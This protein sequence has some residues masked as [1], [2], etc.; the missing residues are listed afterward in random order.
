MIERDRIRAGGA[1]IEYE[2]H[3]S[4]R[5]KKT[6]KITVED[7]IVRIFVPWNTQTRV[8]RKIVREKAQLIRDR[9]G[10]AAPLERKGK[11]TERDSITYEG[12]T[13]AYEVRRSRRRKKSI[14]MTLEKGIVKLAA[15]QGTSSDKLR[16]MVRDWA[17]Q[18]AD[19]LSLAP[20]EGVQKRFVSGEYMPYMGE[21][22][23][24]VIRSADVPLPV[25]AFDGTSG[26]E[27]YNWVLLDQP[28]HFSKGMRLFKRIEFGERLDDA[29]FRITVPPNM[30]KNE[31][32]NAVRDAFIEW[33]RER[34]AEKVAKCVDYHWPEVGRK[35]KPPI[36][37]RDQRRQWGSCASDGTLRFN[38]RLI[39][40]DPDLIEYIV[41]HELAHLR[42]R[43][44]SPR[45][46][47]RVADMVGDVESI[48]RRLRRVEGILPL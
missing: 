38:W 32:H 10:A 11:E 22:V 25:I 21:Y 8:T 26:S 44:H 33:Y 41:A 39:M 14:G 1:T 34:A 17:P 35:N 31:R 29:R 27:E 4:K 12:T 45:F 9:L 3:R 43:S 19:S 30:K 48:R 37:V 46:W 5:R 28:E 7:G 6:A 24:L 36:L 16:T 15:P 40:L 20:P 13:I 42:V 47:D 23:R 18:V 2:V